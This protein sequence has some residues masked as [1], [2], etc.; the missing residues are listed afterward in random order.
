MAITAN[1]ARPALRHLWP[2]QIAG[3]AD[4]NLYARKYGVSHIAARLANIYGPD[5]TNSH[6]IPAIVDQL[7]AGADILHLGTYRSLPRFSLRGRSGGRTGRRDSVFVAGR[8]SRNRKPRSGTGMAGTGGHRHP[9]PAQRT[10]RCAASPTR[11]ECVRW[12]ACTCAQRSNMPVNGWVGLRVTICARALKKP[13]PGRG[14][15]MRRCSPPRKKHEDRAGGKV[16]LSD[17]R[18]GGTARP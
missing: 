15:N 6:V 3:R 18:R 13:L 1:R 9:V 7:L 12:S 10:A 11:T 16:R 8:N 17:P 2:E 14:P 4:V 5:E